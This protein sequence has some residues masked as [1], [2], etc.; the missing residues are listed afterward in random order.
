MAGGGTSVDMR[1]VSNE[2][3]SLKEEISKTNQAIGT[4]ISNMEGYFGFGGSAVKG[5]GR[6]TIKAGTSVL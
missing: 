4:L 2:I 3:S 5:I 6:E 1:P